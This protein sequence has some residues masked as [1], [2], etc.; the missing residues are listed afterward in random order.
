MVKR[1]IPLLM[2]VYALWQRNRRRQQRIHASEGENSA[3]KPAA[4]TR[5]EGEGGALRD[6]PRQPA[7]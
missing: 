4:V 5:W 1:L 3:V 6:G 7:A 2:T